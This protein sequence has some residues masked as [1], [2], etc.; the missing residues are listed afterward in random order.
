MHGTAWKL[1]NDFVTEAL[2]VFDVSFQKTQQGQGYEL[3][4]QLFK[5]QISLNSNYDPYAVDH[6]SWTLFFVAKKAKIVH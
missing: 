3:L 5:I 6:P 1:V 4:P 2:P